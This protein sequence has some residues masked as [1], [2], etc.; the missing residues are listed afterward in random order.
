[1]HTHRWEQNNR[2]TNMGDVWIIE[3]N[4]ITLKAI[5]IG[6][7]GRQSKQNSLQKREQT[8]IYWFFIRKSICNRH[9][10]HFEFQLFDYLSKPL[11]VNETSEISN[12]VYIKKKFIYCHWN[13]INIYLKNVDLIIVREKKIERSF[14]DLYLETSLVFEWIFLSNK[15]WLV[16]S[17]DWVRLT[18]TTKCICIAQIS[19]L[20]SLEKCFVLL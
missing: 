3:K 18:M 6:H 17:I 10:Q 19:T 20:I 8:D 2:R 15:K 7:Q 11:K 14:S 9:H 5:S 4:Q 16:R 1:M 13:Y 12:S